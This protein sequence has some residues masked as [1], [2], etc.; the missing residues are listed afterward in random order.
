VV[1]AVLL[2]A[3]LPV[4]CGH[5]WCPECP[6]E[7]ASPPV[8][9]EGQGNESNTGAVETSI[10]SAGPL[11]ACTWPASLDR[12]DS[13]TAGWWVSRTLL[14]CGDPGSGPTSVC[15][16]D[17]G[18]GT[19]GSNV[20]PCVTACGENQYLVMEEV[21]MPVFGSPDGGPYS[22]TL[23]FPRLPPGCTSPSPSVASAEATYYCC[24][25]LA[26]SM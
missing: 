21:Q 26:A 13:S 20:R 5:A 4:A 1:V 3:G 17:G 23:T 15:A 7:T 14:V 22:P 19:C 16:S 25:C 10:P 18:T 8:S 6:E 12:P 24:P 11:P 2:F 9:A